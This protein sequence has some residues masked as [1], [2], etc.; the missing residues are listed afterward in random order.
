MYYIKTFIIFL[1]KYHVYLF[2]FNTKFENNITKKIKFTL[3]QIKF[4]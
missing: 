1:L 2:Y 4:F 3:I